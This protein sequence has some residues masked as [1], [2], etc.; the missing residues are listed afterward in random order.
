MEK[1]ATLVRRPVNLIFL[2]KVNELLADEPEVVALIREDAVPFF[3]LRHEISFGVTCG[4]FDVRRRPVGLCYAIGVHACVILEM[5]ETLAPML[6]NALDDLPLVQV[7]SC[8]VG[9]WLV[10]LSLPG[11]LRFKAEV[12][13]DAIRGDVRKNRGRGFKSVGLSEPPEHIA[14]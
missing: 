3:D 1:P 12:G 14:P 2:T 9:P 6:L 13:G 5:F 11:S 8:F 4:Y 7:E 10:F